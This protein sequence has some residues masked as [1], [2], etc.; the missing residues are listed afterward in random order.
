MKQNNHASAVEFFNKSLA[1]HRTKDVVEKLEQC[2][3]AIAE[4]ERLAYINP[5][6]AQQEKEKGNTFY[7]NGEL[8]GISYVLCGDFENCTF[9]C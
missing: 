8:A 5:E 4:A 2:K 6:I 7:K 3:K 1:E 9:V